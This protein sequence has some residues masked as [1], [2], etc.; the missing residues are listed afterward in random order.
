MTANPIRTAA[1]ATG[2]L[3]TGTLLETIVKRFGFVLNVGET[4]DD[5]DFDVGEPPLLVH[6][7]VTGYD[8]YLD[9][10]D[11][12]T[13]DDG[14]TCLVSGN[15]LRY[16]IEDAASISLNSVLDVVP[17]PTGSEVV[18]DAYRVDAAATGDFAGHDDD[19]AILTRRG[20]VFAAPE[21]G[22]TVLNLATDKNEQFLATGWGAFVNDVGDASIYPGKM[23]FPLGVSVESETNTPAV[24]PAA[25]VHYLTGSL[26]TGAWAGHARQVVRYEDGG[27]LFYTNY[28]GA[29]IYNKESAQELVYEAAS[30]L[31]K[32]A[33]P[34]A[35]TCQGRLTLESGVAISTSDQLAKAK[36]REVSAGRAE[37]TPKEVRKTA[38]EAKTNWLT[39]VVGFFGAI[40]GA[41]I[42]FFNWVI[43]SFGDIRDFVQPALDLLTG[44]PVWLYA[45]AFGGGALWLYLNGRKGEKASVEAVQG[46][47]RR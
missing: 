45:L 5:F 41:A 21:I 46:G 22:L 8:Y 28:A 36:P 37:A 25:G 31:W 3:V 13:V 47:A 19:I 20:W 2:G 42:A 1:T 15:G 35:P 12:T 16:H 11:T 43:E 34:I 6:Y 30:G 14:L 26:P 40:A 23:L 29:R 7:A 27:W 39:K 4:L 32:P 17:A 9:T 33:L 10:T 24:G 44:L 18:G 38:P